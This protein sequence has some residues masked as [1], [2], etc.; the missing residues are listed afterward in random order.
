[1]EL[2]FAKNFK[3]KKNFCCY[4]SSKRLK[5]DYMGPLLNGAGDL[6]TDTQKSEVLLVGSIPV[7]CR[8]LQDVSLIGFVY[9]PMFKTN[10]I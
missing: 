7:A 8:T 5:K 2:T 1:M 9:F 3:D 6:V 10:Q 4:F